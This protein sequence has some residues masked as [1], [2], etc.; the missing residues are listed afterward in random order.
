MAI[1]AI[2]IERL[3]KIGLP[4][5]EVTIKDLAGDGNHYEAHVAS[6]LFLGKT[7]LQQHKMVYDAL[8]DRMGGLLHALALKT[9][10]HQTPA[11]ATNA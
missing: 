6:R 10:V 2:E 3:I 8:G 4:D 11:E 1:H 9:A 5:A 7:L